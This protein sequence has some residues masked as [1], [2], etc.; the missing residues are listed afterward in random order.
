M[1]D[2]PMTAEERQR[3][4]EILAA[5]G[6]IEPAEL[7]ATGRSVLAL[8]ARS[9]EV[10]AEGLRN[11]VA[12]AYHSGYC[13]GVEGADTYEDGVP[14][15]RHDET[16]TVTVSASELVERGMPDEAVIGVAWHLGDECIAH[17]LAGAARRAASTPHDRGTLIYR[18]WWLDCL[19]CRA[20]AER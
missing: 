19:M 3:F 16:V 6:G 12:T 15:Y 9:G 11:L 2:S 10:M 5:A 18:G 7:T 4:N 13:A 14:F 20:E 17:A 1:T 8:L